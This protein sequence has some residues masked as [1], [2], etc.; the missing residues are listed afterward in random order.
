MS[1][2]QEQVIE[3]MSAMS[4]IEVAELV[5]AIE[6]KFGNYALPTDAPSEIVTLA[7]DYEKDS[8]P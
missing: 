1:I 2:S 4:V 3:A 6:E 8:V 7:E 5:K